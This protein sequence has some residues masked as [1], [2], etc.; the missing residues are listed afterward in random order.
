MDTEEETKDYSLRDMEEMSLHDILEY[1]KQLGVY[2]VSMT[3]GEGVGCDD[4]D[5]ARNKR[6]LKIY[7][8]PVGY[9]GEIAVLL[10]GSLEEIRNFKIAN[11][12]DYEKLDNPP[13]SIGK[14]GSGMYTWGTKRAVEDFFELGYKI[15]QDLS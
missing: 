11:T 3:Y 15:T 14:L 10:K 8:R 7:Y 13:P 2:D 4:L 12:D 5:I 6:N 1:V 9:L